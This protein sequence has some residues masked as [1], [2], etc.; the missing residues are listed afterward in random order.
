MKR[1]VVVA[2]LTLLAL[3]GCNEAP[4]STPA[5]VRAS[6]ELAAEPRAAPTPT[7]SAETAPTPRAAPA[8]TPSQRP[9]GKSLRLLTYN[10]LATPIFPELRSGAVLAILEASDADVIALQEVAGWFLHELLAAPWVTAKG[11]HLSESQGQPFAPGG[12]LLLA[13]RPFHDVSAAV[14][15][16]RQRRVLLV[17]ELEIDGRL[18]AV[19]TTHMESFLEDGPVRAQQLDGI[20]ELLGAADDAVFLGDLNFGDGEQPETDRLDAR[21]VDPWLALHPGDPG[22][23][24]NNEENP[25]AGI[26][27]FVGEPNRRLDRIL[28]RSEA[29]TA[30]SCAIIGDQA[31]GRRPLTREQR[32]R[33]QMPER[34]MP[35]PEP[36][37]IDVFPS[38]HYGLIADLVA[39]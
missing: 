10:V 19:A 37:T 31:A 25:I 33:I 34:P 8:P 30:K 11:Y 14:L 4:P 38:D 28:V 26:G 22:F 9:Q 16:G 29:W 2:L 3:A 13:K 20:F 23:T 32:L 6:N 35:P 24:W 5:P 18:M 39:R 21:Y 27:A 17:G 7:P 12:Q 1:T 15:P 36:V